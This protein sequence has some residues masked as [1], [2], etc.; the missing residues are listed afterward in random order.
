MKMSSVKI[1]T[2]FATPTKFCVG[3]KPDQSVRA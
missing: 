1:L 3:L 2:K